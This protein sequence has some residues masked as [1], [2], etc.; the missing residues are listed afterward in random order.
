MCIQSMQGPIHLEEGLW[1]VGLS[2][3]GI[4]TLV[5]VVGNS[6]KAEQRCIA[7]YGHASNQHI[8]N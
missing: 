2:I 5:Q 8:H 7:G 6:P 3:K 1:K 4:Y